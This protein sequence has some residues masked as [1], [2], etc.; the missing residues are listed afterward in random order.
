MKYGNIF[1]RVN[2]RSGG[3]E[4]VVSKIISI[5]ACFLLFIMPET[6]DASAEMSSKNSSLEMKLGEKYSADLVKCIDGDTAHFNINGHDYKTKFLYIQTPEFTNEIEPYGKEASVF[7]CSFLMS[8]KITLE[9]DGDFLFDEDG[10][11]LAWVWVNNQLHQEEMAKAGFVEAIIDNGNY[12]YEDQVNKAME[13]A[14]KLSKGIYTS[15]DFI[16]KGAIKA[17]KSIHSSSEKLSVEKEIKEK[18]QN[19]SSENFANPEKETKI[20][21]SK[22]SSTHVLA[23]LMIL[24]LLVL[25]VKKRNN[26]MK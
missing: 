8:G 17:S 6:M 15:K 5:M 24:F 14:K 3:I 7:T 2:V 11:L 20:N 1:N 26:I 22:T 12:K 23:G 4:K 13:N 9:T 25:F 19:A 21:Q 18:L 16:E 10:Q